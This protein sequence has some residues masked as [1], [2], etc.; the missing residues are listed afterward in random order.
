MGLELIFNHYKKIHFKYQS[1]PIKSIYFTININ[2]YILKYFLLAWVPIRSVKPNGS[3]T[4]NQNRKSLEINI[5]FIC[6]I[7]DLNFNFSQVLFIIN[8]QNHSQ[9]SY[10][11]NYLLITFSLILVYFIKF[12][13]PFIQLKTAVQM[14]P[15]FKTSVSPNRAIAI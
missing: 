15:S 1:I 10:S 6:I 14:P 9:R 2:I 5:P 7:P 4:I 13:D 3:P 8:Y 12:P 11:N